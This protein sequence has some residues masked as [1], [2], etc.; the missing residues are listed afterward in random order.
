M[1]VLLF[2]AGFFLLGLMVAIGF[3]VGVVGAMVVMQLKFLRGMKMFW[4]AMLVLT[5]L[6]LLFLGGDVA[7][8]FLAGAL[9]Q[10]MWG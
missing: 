7:V 2:V 4:A 8:G 10:Q 6:L 1:V 9:V 3:L 5:L